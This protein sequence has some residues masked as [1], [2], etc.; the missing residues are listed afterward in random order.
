MLGLPFK[1]TLDTYLSLDSIMG[2]VE[3]EDLREKGENFFEEL[4]GEIEI[5]T[6][7]AAKFIKIRVWK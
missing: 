6:A 7:I 3:H 1:E 4:L 5:K 2:V